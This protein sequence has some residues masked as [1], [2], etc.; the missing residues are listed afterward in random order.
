MTSFPLRRIVQLEQ[1]VM[2]LISNAMHAV[3]ESVKENKRICVKTYQT[4]TAIIEISDN[5]KGISQDIKEKIFQPF[6][7]SKEVGKGTGLGLSTTHGIVEQHNGSISVKSKPGQGTTFTIHFPLVKVEKLKEPSPQ[8]ELV[9]GKGQK[10]LIVD[11]ERP[12]L[13][14]ITKALEA[15]N[16]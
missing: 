2:N 1:V 13:D 16:P 12:A 7:T 14:A 15:K 5:G 8:K 10:V 3:E 4:D 11:D 6:F 9:H